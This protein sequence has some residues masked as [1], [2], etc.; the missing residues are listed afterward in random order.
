MFI[1][2]IDMEVDMGKNTESVLLAVQKNRNLVSEKWTPSV[3][4]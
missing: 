1:T 2:S 4:L 3:R